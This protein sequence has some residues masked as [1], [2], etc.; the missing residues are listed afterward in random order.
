[1]KKYL[2]HEI[3]GEYAMTLEDGQQTYDRV[4]PDLKEGSTVE[5]DFERV[6][7]FASPFFNAAIGQLLREFSSAEL[8]QQLSIVNLSP[9]GRNA[10]KR[11]IEN[12]KSPKETQKLVDEV[13]NQMV[14]FEV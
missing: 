8:N 2:V 14:E 7:Y 3:V 9:V 5:L 11:V 1:M 4:F 10:L 6:C 13:I 12:S